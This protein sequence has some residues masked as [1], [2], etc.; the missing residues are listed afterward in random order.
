MI[1]RIDKI[2]A[3]AMANGHQVIVLG[4]W[5]CGVFGN[6][7]E[8]VAKYFRDYLMAEDAK[9]KDSFSAVYFAIPEEEKLN[10]FQSIFEGTALLSKPPTAHY[11]PPQNKNY[12]NRNNNRKEKRLDDV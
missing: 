10:L 1:E 3:V 7:I 11:H 8:E 12:N 6:R 5:G 2:L 4:A 9:Y